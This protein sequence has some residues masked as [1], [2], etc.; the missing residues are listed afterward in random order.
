[1]SDNTG[2]INIKCL[3]SFS[4]L[5]IK[6]ASIA[7]TALSGVMAVC[8]FITIFWIATVGLN[9]L[10]GMLITAMGLSLLKSLFATISIAYTSQNKKP[11]IITTADCLT[12]ACNILALVNLAHTPPLFYSIISIILFSS[13]S[14][15]QLILCGINVAQTK[16]KSQ[17]SQQNTVSEYTDEQAHAEKIYTAKKILFAACLGMLF[18]IISAFGIACFSAGILTNNLASMN[19]SAIL[20]LVGIGGGT[21]AACYQL[22]KQPSTPPLTAATL[23]HLSHETPKLTTTIPPASATSRVLLVS[24]HPSSNKLEPD[25][26]EKIFKDATIQ[27]STTPPTALPMFTTILQ[28]PAPTT[29]AQI[30]QTPHNPALPGP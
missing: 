27:P 26:G 6:Y 19:A 17:I 4:S 25:Q 15:V 9:A 16:K 23:N 1:M 20:M 14:L 12:H 21:T 10:A 18:C 5:T 11:A 13:S 29:A 28:P 30:S 7:I 8:G 3:K 2:Q 22:L 24:S